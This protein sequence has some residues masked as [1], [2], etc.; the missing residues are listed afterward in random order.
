MRDVHL[1]VTVHGMWGLP[2][3]LKTA[4]ETLQ[5]MHREKSPKPAVDL[6]FLLAETSSDV[7]TYDGIDWCAERVVQ[8]VMDR[9]AVLEEDGLRR[10]TRFSICSFSLG[11]LIA[12]YTIGIL[13]DRGFF[14]DVIAI[15]FTTFASPHLGLIEYHTWAGKMT[16]FTVTRMLSRVGPQFYGRDKWTPDG[17]SLLLAMSDPEEIFFKALSSF[18]SVRIYANG[19]QDPDVPF[20]TASIST[21]DPFFDYDRSGIQIQ[22]EPKYHPI[23][24]SYQMPKDLA[25]SQRSLYR[26]L[27][28]PRGVK[29]G[30]QS[31]LVCATLPVLVPS[32]LGVYIVRYAAPNCASRRRIKAME[33]TV[34]AEARLVRLWDTAHREAAISDAETTD[35]RVDPRTSDARTSRSSTRSADFMERMLREGSR[36]PQRGAPELT[37]LQKRMAANLNMIPHMKKYITF[38][39]QYANVHEVIVCKDPIGL[40]SHEAGRGV[41]RHWADGFAF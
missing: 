11:G 39:P 33:R 4:A 26:R 22:Y 12:R 31:V 15:D 3:D 10:V 2:S 17:Q 8:E 16:R 34:P 27:S 14:H 21:Y 28:V 35:T 1:L 13:Y 6:E 37:A 7:H 20:L 23:I 29:N 36:P 30:V 24:A 18:S 41:I 40:P 25:P 9:K 19:I 38:I 5:K 32:L